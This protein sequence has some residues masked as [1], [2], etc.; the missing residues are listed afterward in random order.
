MKVR[1]QQFHHQLMGL[2]SLGK[3][4]A[5]DGIVLFVSVLI[6]SLFFPIQQTWSSKLFPI[7]SDLANGLT[8]LSPLTLLTYPMEQSPSWE[9]NWFCSQSRNSLHFMEPEGS[10][11]HSWASMTLQ[12]TYITTKMCITKLLQNYSGSWLEHFSDSWFNLWLLTQHKAACQKTHC[13]VKL[14]A[15]VTD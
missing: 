15:Y 5:S 2:L 12:Q 11:P 1:K 7:H 13:A 4:T 6:K 9:A 10:L 3:R 8:V 14:L